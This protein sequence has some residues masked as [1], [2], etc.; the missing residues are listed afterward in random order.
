MEFEEELRKFARS[1]IPLRHT[2]ESVQWKIEIRVD[3][4]FILGEAKDV[5]RGG[6]GAFVFP[7][8]EWQN[9]FVNGLEVALKFLWEDAED[10]G[11]HYIPARVIWI[12][13]GDNGWEIGFEFYDL[14]K[15]AER[16]I[17]NYMM[18]RIVSRTIEDQ[19]GTD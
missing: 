4:Q 8:P 17:A 5:S 19:R 11:L 14:D 16:H 15:S 18:A 6:L 12:R 13:N 10:K 9:R 1:D 7:G 3:G 2:R